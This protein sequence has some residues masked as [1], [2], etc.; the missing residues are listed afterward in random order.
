MSSPSQA[1][2]RSRID[3]K[4]RYVRSTSAFREWVTADGSSGFRAEPGR[5][6]LYVSLACPWAH[7][8]II[9][10]MLKG[11][12]DVISM[13]VVDPVRDDRGWA[14]DEGPGAF[15]DPVNGFGFLSEAYRATDPGYEGRI[16]VPVLWDT[17]ERRAVNNDSADI[18]RMLNSA[19]DEWGDRS[20]DL[21]PADLR[22]EI[23]AINEDVYAHVNN[24]VYRA[25]FATTQ[26]AYEEAFDAI[27]ATLDR[28]EGLLGER[29]YLAG[30]RITEADWR[31]FTTLLRFDAV[32][33]LHFKCNLR[34]IADSPILWP[35]ARELYQWPGVAETVN[36]DHIKRH[37]YCTHESIDP[38]RIIPKGPAID[39]TEPHGRG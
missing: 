11:L 2:F 12:Q 15:P 4:G 26:E 10:R 21:Y 17:R 23:D 24:G 33:Y 32:Y 22:D 25:G 18:I 34:R 20:V 39:W 8:A 30:D 37:Y 35:Y 27:F 29:R 38:K 28:V 14:F 36:L 5:Y 13:S 19:F 1:E 6:H 31:L 16:T 3:P 9:V 7:R